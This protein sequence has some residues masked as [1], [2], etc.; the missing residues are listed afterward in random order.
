MEYIYFHNFPDTPT[1]PIEPLSSRHTAPTSLIIVEPTS[2]S[3]IISS[4]HLSHDSTPS[5]PMASL[6]PSPEFI[7][8][9]PTRILPSFPNFYTGRLR[10]VDASI[11]VPSPS[12]QPTYGLRPRPLWHVNRLGLPSIGDVVLEPT[13]YCGVVHTKWHL[14]MA[15][16]TAALERIGAWDI[17]YV[18]PR[19]RPITWWVYKVRTH[20]DGSLGRYKSRVVHNGFQ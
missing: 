1:T 13:S 2:S 18:P 3:P 16:E 9:I 14:V 11:D 5:S 7:P 15:E 4:P 17:V 8:M 6:S 20:S 12:S 10:V 19:V